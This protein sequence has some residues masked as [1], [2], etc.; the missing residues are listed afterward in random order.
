MTYW[1]ANFFLAVSAAAFK[2]STS[3]V[4]FLLALMSVILLLPLL[5]CRECLFHRDI[6]LTITFPQTSQEEDGLLLNVPLLNRVSPVS[7]S[8]SSMKLLFFAFF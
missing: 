1:S 4:R 3:G 5:H 7:R 2:V 6:S 8:T